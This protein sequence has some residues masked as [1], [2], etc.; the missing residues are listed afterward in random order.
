MQIKDVHRTR[1]VTV[2][3]ALGS[4]I[5]FGLAPRAGAQGTAMPAAK[6]EEAELPHPFFTH[7]GLPEGVGNFNLR[8]LGL[9]TRTD[10]KTDGDVAF[11]LETGLTPT[12]GL[13]IRNDR[14]QNNGKTEAMFQ[15][16]AYVSKDGMS[17]FAPIIEFEIPTKA[18]AS[19]IGTL[20]GFTSSLGTS[21]WA[22]N[23]VLHYDPREEMSDVS[24]ALVFKVSRKVFPVL[25]ILGAGGKGQFTTVN[26]LAG[27]KVRL[28]DWLIAGVAIQFPVTRAQNFSS[29]VAAGPDLEWKR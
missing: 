2:G 24:A 20:V 26:G 14:F 15:F 3:L 6:A 4:I 23:Q 12:I 25:E 29:Q 16:A 19:G 5:L 10:G 28:R 27:I 22:F 7:M 17:G 21:R 8:L 18:G 1:I 9:A 13:H 11:H